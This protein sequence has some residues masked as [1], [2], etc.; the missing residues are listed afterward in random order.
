MQRYCVLDRSACPGQLQRETTF[1][2]MRDEE[3]RRT[4][5]MIAEAR[6]QAA[7]AAGHV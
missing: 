6:K 2:V 3:E 1:A 5:E 4:N 7:Q